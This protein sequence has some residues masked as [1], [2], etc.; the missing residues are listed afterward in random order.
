MILA[1]VRRS[2]RY[3]VGTTLINLGTALMYK[4]FEIVEAQ[5]RSEVSA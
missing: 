5:W 1:W 2:L 3:W 4:G